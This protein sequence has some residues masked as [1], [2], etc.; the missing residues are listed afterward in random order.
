MPNGSFNALLKVLLNK[1]MEGFYSIFQKIELPTL[2]F[3]DTANP[4][5]EKFYHAFTLGIIVNLDDKYLV[6]SNRESGFGRYD[7]MIIPNDKNK[8]GIIIEFKTANIFKKE[9]I[10]EAVKAAME[11]IDECKYETELQAMG[12]N[13]ILKLAIAFSSK[14][15]LLEWK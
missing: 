14:E 3:N 4:E 11:Q 2:S 7:V 6:K 5:P 13:D 12:V 10:T 8:T 15:I 1:N 9:S